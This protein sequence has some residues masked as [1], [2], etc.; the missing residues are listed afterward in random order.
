M[1]EVARRWS[2]R[3]SGIMVAI[4]SI[5]VFNAYQR[6]IKTRIARAESLGREVLA[7]LKSDRHGA[8]RQVALS[9]PTHPHT[10]KRRDVMAAPLTTTTR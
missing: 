3:R 1:S 9:P 4:P 7:Y 8:Q 6:V 2:R 10:A 5:A